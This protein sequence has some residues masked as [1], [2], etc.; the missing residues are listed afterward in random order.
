MR[1]LWKVTC[2]IGFVLVVLGVAS[3][4]SPSLVLPLSLI[5]S[6]AVMI[7]VSAGGESKWTEE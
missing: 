3:F 1:V 5:V 2:G 4:S 6:G 7:G